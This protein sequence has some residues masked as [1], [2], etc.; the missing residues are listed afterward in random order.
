MRVTEEKSGTKSS[1][2]LA[3]PARPGRDMCA[4][5]DLGSNSF[6]LMILNRN[7]AALEV[8]ER[9]KEK[10]QLANKFQN[11]RICVE[12]SKRG[13]DCLARFAQRLRAIPR[14]NIRVVGTSALR[15]ARNAD[16]FLLAASNILGREVEVIDG[17]EE[18]RLIY[19]GVDRALPGSDL[20][21]S[22]QRLV[23]DIGGGSTEFARGSK[24]GSEALAS[25]HLGCVELM[26]ACFD[27]AATPSFGYRRARERAVRILTGADQEFHQ[28]FQKVAWHEVLGTSGTIESIQQVLAANGWSA[29]EITS[30][31]LERLEAAILDGR[32]VLDMAVPGLQRERSDIF[33]AGV[34]ILRSIFAILNLRSMKFVPATLMEG[35]FFDR[36]QNSGQANGRGPNVDGFAERFQP[37]PHQVQRVLRTATRLLSGVTDAWGLGD[38]FC[39]EALVW[40]V[41]LHEIGLKVSPMHYH[42]HGA[43]LIQNGD[44]WGFSQR[45]K[46]ALALLVRSHRRGFQALSFDAFQEPQSQRL[47][48]LCVL[49]RLAVIL[50]RGRCDETSPEVAAEVNE[51]VLTLYLP[52]GWLADNALSARELE[53]EKTQLNNIGIDLLTQES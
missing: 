15:E 13:L 38:T 8:L 31:S 41:K 6:H 17:E 5:L 49:L 25:C 44:L 9:V 53:I 12:S 2:D 10:V 34:A 27:G 45:E 19:L 29:D 20:E 4:V 24:A 40:A 33:P 37:D 23:I 51:G 43:Y 47:K 14:G 36:L 28:K 35:V 42:R 18:A 32:W 3:D 50:E 22:H 30:Q 26:N 52:A 16:E 48:C 39:K 7:S 21:A 1:G 11:G 46:Q